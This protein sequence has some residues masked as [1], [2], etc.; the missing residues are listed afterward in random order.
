MDSRAIFEGAGWEAKGNPTKKEER[1]VEDGCKNSVCDRRKFVLARYSG[2][3]ARGRCHCW[4]RTDSQLHKGWAWIGN[5]IVE[6]DGCLGLLEPHSEGHP[7]SP[8]PLALGR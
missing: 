3:W 5:S 1:K 6:S 8:E 4:L 7:A 2:Q